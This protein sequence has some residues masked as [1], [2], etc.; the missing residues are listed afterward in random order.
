MI[1]INLE[2]EG[3]V[4][5]EVKSTAA[6]ILICCL[7]SFVAWS[8][9]PIMVQEYV[10]FSLENV[11]TGKLWTA[12]SAIFVHS[13]TLHLLGNMLFLFVFGRTLE[14][15][16]G[17]RRMV[18]SFLLGGVISFFSTTLFYPPDTAMVGA[19]AAIFTL[20]AIAMLVKP[21]KFSWIFLSPVGLIALIYFLYNVVIVYHGVQSTISYIGHVI[22]F[23]IGVPLGIAWSRKWKTN[24]L[25]TVLL[26]VLYYVIIEFILGIDILGWIG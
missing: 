24:M 5:Q 10:V 26:L 7:F 16:L 9:D 23:V 20:A 1:K 14:E 25:L 12:I 21:L 17:W 18:G 19:S 4:G 11:L 3:L 15:E 6:L 13:S 2:Y 8:M 22:G